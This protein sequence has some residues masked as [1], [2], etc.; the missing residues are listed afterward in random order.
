[1]SLLTLKSVTKI[2]L[3]VILIILAV[4]LLY[5]VLSKKQPLGIRIRMKRWVVLLPAVAGVTVLFTCLTVAYRKIDDLTSAS[6]R[7]GYNYPEASKGLAPNGIHLDVDEILSEDV[8]EET[9][10]RGGW[11]N[12]TTDDLKSALSI[13]NLNPQDSVSVDKQYLSTEYKVN[14]L[15]SP[16]TWQINGEELLVV[17]SQTY[18]D[19]FD[20]KYGRK[21]NVINNDFS[22]IPNL[23]YLDVYTYLKC[24]IN[25]ISDYMDMCSSVQSSSFVSTKT[26]ESFKSISQKAQTYRGNAL[27]RYRAYVLNYGISKDK[28]QYISRLNYDNQTLNKRYMNNLVAYTT[29]LAAIDMYDRD[30]TTVVLVP[31]RDKDGEFYQSRTKI[32][33]DYFAAEADEYLTVVTDRQLD[34]ETNNY[35]IQKFMNGNAT[36]E[37]IAKADSMIADLQTQIVQISQLAEDTIRDYET[38]HSDNNLSFSSENPETLLEEVKSSLPYIVLVFVMAS[39][40]AFSGVD[41]L[42]RKK[43]GE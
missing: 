34:I 12:V 31:T 6:I 20:E 21:Y 7:I 15:A 39:V 22:E 37:S 14:Y 4:V 42:N 29:R 41:I 8:L 1:M 38:R 2:L 19:Y 32:G 27:E 28:G 18:Q 25:N 30:I 16:Q 23:D 33:T 40:I 13:K 3:L 26:N 35:I 24:R 5:S 36:S 43:A 9:I 17:L 11:E 10:S